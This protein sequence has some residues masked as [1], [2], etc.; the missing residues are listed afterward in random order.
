MNFSTVQIA[1]ML[2][3]YEEEHHAGMDLQMY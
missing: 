1:G 2:K 3:E